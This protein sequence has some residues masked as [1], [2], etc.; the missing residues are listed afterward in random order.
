MWWT[1]RVEVTTS[2]EPSGS[3]RS[4]AAPTG[5]AQRDDPAV[6]P[7]AAAAERDH[8]GELVGPDSL[9]DGALTGRA[10]L[11]DVVQ[12]GDPSK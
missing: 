8:A 3:P 5:A 6:D 11:Q 2:K 7:A 1:A 12:H 10:G 9:D 4:W